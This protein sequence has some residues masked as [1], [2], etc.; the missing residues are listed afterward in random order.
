MI[1]IPGDHVKKWYEGSFSQDLKWQ[2]FGSAF[3]FDMSS[4]RA[5][6]VYFTSQPS[7]I[8]R[9]SGRLSWWLLVSTSQNGTEMALWCWQPDR[10]DDFKGV[11]KPGKQWE[12]QMLTTSSFTSLI[13]VNLPSNMSCWH[14]PL[15]SVQVG[16][17]AK[18]VIL[19]GMLLGVPSQL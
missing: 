4:S 6:Q 9:S 18:H 7:V 10:F 14:L 17:P 8:L 16:F 11:F 5:R 15:P 13:G 3:N 12:I 1:T 2:F 19:L